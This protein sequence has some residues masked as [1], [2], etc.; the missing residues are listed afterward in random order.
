[1]GFCRQIETSTKAEKPVKKKVW[2]N[3]GSSLI[4]D[5]VNVILQVGDPNIAILL[6][7]NRK[8]NGASTQNSSLFV[9]DEPRSLS[10]DDY[11]N[12][13]LEFARL[14]QVDLFVPS[15]HSKAIVKARQSFL[16]MGTAL[17]AAGDAGLMET[18]HHKGRLFERLAEEQIPN[19][20]DW[21]I[22]SDL[23]G[24][25]SAYASL[26]L[27]HSKVC[28]KPAAGVFG[29][30]FRLIN[31]EVRAYD[32]L[33]KTGPYTASS[34]ISL[35]EARLIF[36]QTERFDDLML[37]QY[38]DGIERSIDCL[39]HNGSLVASIIRAKV[40]HDSQVI[41]NNQSLQDIVAKITATLG[42][43]GVFNIQFKDGGSK[44]AP[45]LLE[46]NPRMSGGLSKGCL[47][48]SFPLPYWAVRLALGTCNPE[49]VP[50]PVTGKSLVRVKS[51]EICD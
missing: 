3:S 36:G 22:A 28:F 33:M 42:L 51:Y 30:G 46:I 1:M 10:E 4:Y 26:R 25:D 50:L 27:S 24:F 40:S 11:V 44:H 15:H 8:S 6:T 32:R 37:M 38:L 45:F 20:P 17:M 16:S 14:H 7:G 5:A 21:L 47:A 49:Y 13:C 19:I 29:H 41:E 34:E 23:A 43:S 48:S 9:E 39:A 35:S 2:F 12:W 18:M 31:E